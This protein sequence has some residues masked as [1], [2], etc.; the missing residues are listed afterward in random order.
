MRIEVTE[1][2]IRV[3]V[4]GSSHDCPIAQAFRRCG[5]HDV[6]VDEVFAHFPDRYLVLPDEAVA[7]IAAF[8]SGLSVAPFSFELEGL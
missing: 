8:D 5:Y 6:V 2:D 4:L 7:F 1:E 3:G